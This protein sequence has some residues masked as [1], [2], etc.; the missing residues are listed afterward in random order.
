MELWSKESWEDILLRKKKYSDF[1]A[2]IGFKINLPEYNYTIDDD[3]NSEISETSRKNENQGNVSPKN[4]ID[5][6][7]TSNHNLIVQSEI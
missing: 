6:S 5:A 1:C 7:E 3:K 2:F 4:S